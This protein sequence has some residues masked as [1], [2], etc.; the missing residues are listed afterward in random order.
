[1]ERKIMRSFF[2][3]NKMR[4]MYQKGIMDE[5]GLSGT[6]NMIIHRV[7]DMGPCSQE[8]I[9]AESLSDKASISRDC[10]KLQT[11]GIIKQETDPSNKRKRL[12]SLTEQGEEVRSQ[13]LKADRHIS[14]IL[15][16]DISEEE[17][18]LLGE[19]LSRMEKNAAE[20]IK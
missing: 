15:L 13:L 2:R 14:D 4:R 3:A 5:L 16:K 7:G 8:D 9:S 20:L 1:M 10:S 11:M 18:V 6:M 19:L 12:I 17:K